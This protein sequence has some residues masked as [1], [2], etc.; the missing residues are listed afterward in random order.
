VHAHDYKADFYATLLAR[1]ERVT[2]VATVHGWP[3]RTRRERFLYYPADRRLL[4]AFPLVIAVSAETH[5][6]LVAAGIVAERI[7]TLPNAVDVDLFRPDPDRRARVRAEWEVGDNELVVGS[8]GRLDPEK[9]PDLLVEAFALVAARRLE[10]RKSR[11][12]LVIA[13]RRARGIA[14]ESLAERAGVL[15]RCVLLGHRPDAEDVL[16]GFDVFVQSSDSEGSPYSL[17]EA[18]A[19]GTPVVATAVGDVPALVRPGT[20][21]LLVRRG[22]AAALAAAIE[23][24]LDAPEAARARAEAARARVVAERSLRA[25]EARM[26]ERYRRLI[27]P[28]RLAGSPPLI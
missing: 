15:D 18:M 12:R 10:A 19:S 13:G 22:D 4:Q 7:E 8:L 5:D 16:R 20:D 14:I 28:A 1:F 17:L 24:T 3:V 25:R 9:R 6:Q 21:G 23:E 26:L 27:E 11:V 2:P